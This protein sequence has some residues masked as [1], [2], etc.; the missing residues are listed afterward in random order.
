MPEG[1]RLLDGEL[2][3]PPTGRHL[4]D[5]VQVDFGR[6]TDWQLRLELTRNGQTVKVVF[7]DV[8]SFRVH[9]EAEIAEY[10]T[11]REKEGVAVGTVYALRKSAYL[12][13]IGRGI[14]AIS[15]AL[16]MSYFLLTGNDTCVE[17]IGPQ[18]PRL[19]REASSADS[20][21]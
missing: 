11:T 21:G 4:W 13:E 12:D 8:I 17:V 6:K 9:D 5:I 10:W 18:P 20:Y 3:W 14:S 2:H 7:D 19:I 1:F 15:H 16:P